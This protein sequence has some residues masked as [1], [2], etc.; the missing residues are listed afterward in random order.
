MGDIQMQHEGIGVKSILRILKVL[1]ELSTMNDLSS[2]KSKFPTFPS[3]AENI[4]Q[5][6]LDDRLFDIMPRLEIYLRIVSKH[7]PSVRPAIDPYVSTQIG[8]FSKNF[9][10]W[11]IGRFL[12][13]PDCCIKSFTEEVR[14]GLDDRHFE[15][16]KK[17]KRKVFVTTAGFVPCSVFCKESHSK[18]LASFL[19]KKI[20]H[21]LNLLEKE[22]SIA[23]PHFHPE[24]Q[25]HYYDCIE[26][27]DR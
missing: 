3:F 8:V 17:V 2:V 5:L 19:N 25:G 16:L 12:G 15:E 22:L 24:Y 23:L 11:E 21:K 14:Y 4:C 27:N 1:R 26:I 18:G 7:N 10:D 13:Y 6:F 20:V 9:S